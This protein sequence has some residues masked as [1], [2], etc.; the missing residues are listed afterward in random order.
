MVIIVRNDLIKVK[1]SFKKSVS[2]FL[3]VHK[4]PPIKMVTKTEFCVDDFFALPEKYYNIIGLSILDSS[5]PQTMREKLK[6]LAKSA[7]FCSCIF[8]LILL[9]ASQFVHDLLLIANEI[10]INMPYIA[11]IPFT[12]VKTLMIVKRKRQIIDFI[13]ELR[14]I[15]DGR[16]IRVLQC[17]DLMKFIKVFGSFSQVNMVL[18]VTIIL[19]RIIVYGID[20]V[21]NQLWLP[22]NDGGLFLMIFVNAWVICST[23]TFLLILLGNEILTMTL[24]TLTA[25][26]FDNLRDDIRE[27]KNVENHEKEEALKKLVQDHTALL[28]LSSKL[29]AILTSIIFISFLQSSAGICIIGF[30]IIAVEEIAKRAVF[31]LFLCSNVC[32][33]FAVC[34]FS[35]QIIDGSTSIGGGIFES[36]DWYATKS[37]KLR[38]A[39]LLMILRSQ[40]AQ[41]LTAKRYQTMS[42]ASFGHILSAAYSYFTLLSDLYNK[43]EMN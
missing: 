22:H 25:I 5:R 7:L 38:K 41:T 4:Q 16:K 40:K 12:V 11:N 24:I 18:T 39:Y 8:G 27:L 28:N 36:C 20:R 14:D 30:E 13:S 35:Q 10:P 3:S 37:M 26:S 29:E 31:S 32:Q 42:M 17:R 15:Y 23:I 9:L 19:L 21:T 2:L 43:K 34:F 6:A 1:W 33:I